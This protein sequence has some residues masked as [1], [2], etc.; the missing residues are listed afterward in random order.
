MFSTMPYSSGYRPSGPAEMPC[1]PLHCSP[2]TTMLVLLGL[3]DTQSPVLSM[4]EFWMTTP[5]DR[6][7]SHPS[8]FLASYL[9]VERP[10]MF[11]SLMMK[12]VV[13]AM[14]L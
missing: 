6:Y 8:V 2:C 5:S 12:L 3:K 13:L 14:R 1:D 9:L 10:L 7:V 4:M 11:T